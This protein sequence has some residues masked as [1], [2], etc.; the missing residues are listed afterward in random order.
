[1]LRNERVD[2]RK[3]SDAREQ[4]ACIS[5]LQRSMRARCCLGTS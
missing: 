3:G 5:I 2:K 1:M 4:R